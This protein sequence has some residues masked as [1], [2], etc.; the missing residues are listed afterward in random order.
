MGN[1]LTA[2]KVQKPIRGVLMFDPRRGGGIGRVDKEY[3][4]GV[5]QGLIDLLLHRVPVKMVV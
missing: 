2:K 3:E 1:M 4:V 5:S